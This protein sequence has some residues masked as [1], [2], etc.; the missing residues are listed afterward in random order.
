[1]ITSIG[2]LAEAIVEVPRFGFVKRDGAGR[3][4]LVSPLPCPFNYG[5]VPGTRAPDGEGLDAL[6][7]GPRLPRGARVRLPIVA[8]VSFLDGGLDDPKLVLGPSGL[9]DGDRIALTAFFRAYEVLKRGLSAVTGR[10]GPTRF[11]GLRR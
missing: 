4:D 1:L 11:L 8:V 2:D 9:G 10:P 5:S 6:V 3:I 7:L